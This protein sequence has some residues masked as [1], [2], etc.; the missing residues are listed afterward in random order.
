MVKID[1]LMPTYNH[2]KYIEQ[3]ILSVLVQKL[4]YPFRLIIS[5][6]NSEDDTS[7]IAQKYASAYP[8]KVIFVRNKIRL[9]VVKNYLRLFDLA[10]SEYLAILE[11]D[12]FWTDPNKLS[13]QIN[14][15][16]NNK[17][18]GL[19]HS[20]NKVLFSDGTEKVNHH[21]NSNS[22]KN[23]DLYRSIMLNKFSIAPLTV[24]FRRDLL[25]TLDFNFLIENNDLK[26]IDLFLWPEFL[27]N[28]KIYYIDE[29][30]ASYRNLTSSESNT[31]DV[32]KRERFLTSSRKIKL[33]YLKKYPIE[34]IDEKII[35]ANGNY[36]MVKF[37]VSKNQHDSAI[38]YLSLLP[39]INLSYCFLKL[40][41]FLPFSK[42]WLN[43]YFKS[44]E[45]LSVLKQYVFRL[46]K[47]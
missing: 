39:C 35:M 47:A 1:V 25:N 17:N 33:Y 6:D 32:H 12:D 22:I 20:K 43:I 7:F 46:M 44:Y 19:V 24:C 30:M 2:E 45:Y 37:L 16:D 41:I 42:I 38:K 23:D 26:T 8:D 3:A 36:Q 4:D 14:I 28:T 15:M 10:T 18:I 21:S 5:D 40:S 13:K 29:I 31:S 11:S 9:G 27:K 34:N